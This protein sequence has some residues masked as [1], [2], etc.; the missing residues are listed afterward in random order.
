MAYG[1]TPQVVD[2]VGVDQQ[3]LPNHN[4][5]MGLFVIGFVFLGSFFWLNLLVSVGREGEV[6]GETGVRMGALEFRVEAERSPT[7][8]FRLG[9]TPCA[10]AGLT[11][12]TV[13][14]GGRKVPSGPVFSATSALLPPLLPPGHHRLLLP[15]G[16]GGRGP[17]AGACQHEVVV[18]PAWGRG[19]L[20]SHTRTQRAAQ[21]GDASHNRGS[22]Q[23]L[24][25][26]HVWYH[27]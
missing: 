25:Q 7:L 16:H 26:V 2:A 17:A 27:A 13:A 22:T 20:P 21:L 8:R 4:P 18:V 15:A 3:P 14:M 11:G 9:R 19:V 10:P 12:S 5:W 1:C 6:W 24:L 23:G